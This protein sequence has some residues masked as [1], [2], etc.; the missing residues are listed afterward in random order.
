MGTLKFDAKGRL[1][2]ES[3]ERG[4]YLDPGAE[5]EL[6]RKEFEK[7]ALGTDDDGFVLDRLPADQ[8][9]KE[10]A[11][12][13]PIDPALGEP[14]RQRL[15]ADQPFCFGRDYREAHL[16]SHPDQMTEM[17]RLSRGPSEIASSDGSSAENW[18]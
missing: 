16:S 4:I 17:I 13:D 3:V 10:F 14:L 12:I 18:P 6:S 15:K 8:C 1:V 2:M 9:R 11:S 7:Q 5:V